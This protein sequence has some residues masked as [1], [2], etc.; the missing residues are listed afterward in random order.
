[1]VKRRAKKSKTFDRRDVLSKKGPMIMIVTEGS[2]SEIDYFARLRSRFKLSRSSVQIFASKHSDPTHVVSE[3][4]FQ[5]E[6]SENRFET[7][8]CVFD[9]DNYVRYM[10][11]INSIETLRKQKVGVCKNIVAITSVPCFEY[12][13]FLHVS[14]SRKS[15]GIVGSPCKKLQEDL[16]RY[17][18]FH[19]YDK[20]T[21]HSFFDQIF[22][23]RNQAIERSKEI[24]GSPY[25]ED[26]HNTDP[27][28]RVHLIVEEFE[29]L[30]QSVN[31]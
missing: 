29:R 22:E 7:V 19:N 23:N 18:P 28:T 21:S 6:Q 15:Y 16:R 5:I 10:E 30:S 1:M 9:R 11:A 3:A 2:K 12:W 8:F 13:Y 26:G 27:S 24:L 4:R 17:K 20:S 25:L 31:R 14:D